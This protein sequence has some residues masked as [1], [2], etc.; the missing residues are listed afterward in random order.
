MSEL[1][2]NLSHAKI[3]LKVFKC[4]FQMIQTT[5]RLFPDRGPVNYTIEY[6]REINAL[7][8]G[9][10]VSKN[11]LAQ[12]GGWVT[13]IWLS[14]LLGGNKYWW[15]YKDIIVLCVTELTVTSCGFCLIKVLLLSN[16][17]LL[18]NNHGLSYCFRFW[19]NKEQKQET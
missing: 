18:L 3:L 12:V 6:L 15:I 16:N 10:W 2:Q 8:E 4:T 13:I 19:P 17:F 7:M 1:V 9:Q 11:L 5:F 14:S